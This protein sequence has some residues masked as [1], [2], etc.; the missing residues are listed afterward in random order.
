MLYIYSTALYFI[1]CE[2]VENGRYSLVI[3]LAQSP[4]EDTATNFITP[5]RPAFDHVNSEKSRA[6]NTRTHTP[7]SGMINSQAYL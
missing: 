1:N 7:S 3:L 5:Y 6:F 2:S 4:G